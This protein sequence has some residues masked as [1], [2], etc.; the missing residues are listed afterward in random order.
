MQTIGPRPM[1]RFL[2]SDVAEDGVTIAGC[3][4][5]GATESHERDVEGS[6]PSRSTNC[7]TTLAR[8]IYSDTRN[9]REEI[10]VP[11]IV[12]RLLL[13]KTQGERDGIEELRDGIRFPAMREVA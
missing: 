6:N 9:L 13:L 12:A 2:G 10:A 8:T 11:L 1:E 3:S 5:K 7:L 4:A